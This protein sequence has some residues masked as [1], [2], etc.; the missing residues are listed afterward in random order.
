MGAAFSV[1]VCPVCTPT[2]LV[3]LGVSTGLGSPIF[4]LTLL[5]AFAIGRAGPIL[6]G[7]GAVGWLEKL[8]PLRLAQRLF[9]QIGGVVLIL[10]GFYM[11]NA[12]LFVIPALA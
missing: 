10:A 6:I 4:G 7:A 1:A 9:E 11:L 5:T 2:L 12:Y 3:L 8:E